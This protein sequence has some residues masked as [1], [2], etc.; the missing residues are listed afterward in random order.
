MQYSMKRK[1]WFLHFILGSTIRVTEILKKKEIIFTFCVCARRFMVKA[2]FS[3]CFYLPPIRYLIKWLEVI[4][5]DHR[6][7]KIEIFTGSTVF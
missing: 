2:F 3:F 6:L 4:L 1:N 5:T 7:K